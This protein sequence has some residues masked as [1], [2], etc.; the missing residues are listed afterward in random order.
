MRRQSKQRKGRIESNISSPVA[1]HVQVN[2]A[3]DFPQF[4]LMV[5]KICFINSPLSVL[6]NN[7]LTAR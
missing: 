7:G 1:Q 5:I 4:I 3:T 2:P 6:K